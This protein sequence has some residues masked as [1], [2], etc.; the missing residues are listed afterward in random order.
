MNKIVPTP[1]Q[2]SSN[3]LNKNSGFQE[4]ILK[5]DS[6]NNNI[7]DSK[8]DSQVNSLLQIRQKN[9]EK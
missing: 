3:N 8:N 2:K 9:H 7:N 1:T 5:R 6:I 4:A